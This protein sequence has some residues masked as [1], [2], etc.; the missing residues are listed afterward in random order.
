MYEN[1]F[2]FRKMLA[3]YTKP[4]KIHGRSTRTELLGYLIVSGVLATATNWIV[5]ALGA[6]GA[7]SI[8]VGI[9]SVGLAYLVW[10]LP[11]PALAIRRLHDQ[12]KSGW[13]A[14]LLVLPTAI[15]WLGGKD[16]LGTSALIVLEAIYLAGLVLLF[17]KPT[18]G[19]NR[20]GPDPRLNPEDWEEAAT[21]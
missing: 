8:D 21:E 17:W 19:T 16:F 6:S 15:S 9:T 12:D 13:W 1:S 4:H 11:L 10:W 14:L 18:D 5:I 7:V 3:A 2:T 20:Y